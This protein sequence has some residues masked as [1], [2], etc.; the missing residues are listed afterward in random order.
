MGEIIACEIESGV[1]FDS[2]VD[3]FPS[4]MSCGIRAGFA[5]ST[6]LSFSCHWS[7]VYE[8]GAQIVMI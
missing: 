1:Y 8:C 4:S 6:S 5:L 3:A 2:D 7:I